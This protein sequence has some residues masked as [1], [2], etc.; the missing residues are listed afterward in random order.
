MDDLALVRDLVDDAPLPDRS[1]LAPARA[2]LVA[3]I[4]APT[5]VRLVR[6]RS[7][8]ALLGGTTI[9]LAAAVAAAIT[10][11]PRNEQP[12]ATGP[13]AVKVLTLAAQHVLTAPHVVPRP[14][15]F[16]YARSEGREI[17]QS[18]DGTRD[19]RIVNGGGTPTTL[20]GCRDG[21]APVVKGD[22]VVP[23]VTEECTP[24]P[25]YRADLPTT[26]DAMLQYLDD[27]ASG[28][29]GSVNAR[30][31]DVLSLINEKV[32]SPE[33]RAALFQAASRVPGLE[34]VRDV[35]DS[36]G[37]PAIGIAWP[38]PLGASPSAPPP[39]KP[40]GSGTMILVFDP[41]TY[42]YLGSP[43]RAAGTVTVV[44]EVGQRP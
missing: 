15:Q 44:D 39:G 21:R 42:E 6:H 35:R 28:E 43:T 17:W 1:A 22:E 7:R 11:V 30:G 14:D 26:A 36:T 16:I 34:V 18:V 8:F 9:G 13:D 10:L 27:N 29:P 24:E 4:T 2:R 3:G 37:K 32:L 5:P 12:P 40:V 41:T 25:A 23:G 38:R 31:K 33:S 20:P 19:G